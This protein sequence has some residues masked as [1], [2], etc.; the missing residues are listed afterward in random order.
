MLV[1]ITAGL[2]V[3]LIAS[4][5]DRI[6]AIT[7]FTNCY[8]PSPV[9]LPCDRMVYRGGAL[10]A[11]FSALCGVQLTAA[12]GWLL[13]ELWSAI[14]PKPITDDFLRLLHDSFA[15]DWRKPLTWPWARVAWAYG[16]TLVGASATVGVCVI[17][18]SLVAPQT[19]AVPSIRIET[20]ETFRL[21][22]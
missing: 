14:E 6:V 20:S 12:A 19:A 15:R 18:W 4:S 1:S 2:G 17:L 22:Q 10:Y 9:A 11:L 21:G 3:W 13:W 5:P 8:G 16:F 7:D